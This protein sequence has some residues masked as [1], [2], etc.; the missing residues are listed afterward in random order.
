MLL[1]SLL[2]V[3]RRRPAVAFKILDVKLNEGGG[4]EFRCATEELVRE[5]RCNE[6]PTDVSG[7]PTCEKLE[8]AF[9]LRSLNEYTRVVVHMCRAR[10]FAKRLLELVSPSFNR[11]GLKRR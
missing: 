5:K 3:A 8:A 4:G 7:N 9:P 2:E 10:R 6:N 11:S 1:R